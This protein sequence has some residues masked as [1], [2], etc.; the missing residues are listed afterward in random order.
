MILWFTNM[1]KSGIS[2]FQSFG[3]NRITFHLAQELGCVMAGFQ[4]IHLLKLRS[5]RNTPRSP[6]MKNFKKN[7][8]MN[9]HRPAHF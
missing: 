5:L 3:L 8:P 6:W 9:N 4:P 2:L 1:D 7:R